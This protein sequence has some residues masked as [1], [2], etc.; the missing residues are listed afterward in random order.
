[1]P[2]DPQM[3][4]AVA[5]KLDSLL[6]TGLNVS[7]PSSPLPLDQLSARVVSTTGASTGGSENSSAALPQSQHKKNVNTS[8]S[9][10]EQLA[11]RGAVSTAVS[12]AVSEV[13]RDGSVL[14]LSNHAQYK[15]TIFQPKKARVTDTDRICNNLWLYIWF[16][17]VGPQKSSDSGFGKVGSSSSTAS[18]LWASLS[19]TVPRIDHFYR[20]MLPPMTKK[21]SL[22]L[23]KR[24]RLALP[25][26]SEGELSQLRQR[27]ASH[28]FI[29][30]FSPEECDVAESL[31]DDLFATISERADDLVGRVS[32]LLAQFRR[33][34][35]LINSIL[36][37]RK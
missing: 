26:L 3:V 25:A 29:H 27:V 7:S 19:R 21:D 18:T 15:A 2:P 30:R 22:I 9:S 35:C 31:R 4:S 32:L 17:K 12:T 33:P 13:E 5:K 14:P 10:Q 11:G 1:M 28:E 37:V 34:K 24:V 16:C 20:C 8:Q 23:E 6:G 36:E